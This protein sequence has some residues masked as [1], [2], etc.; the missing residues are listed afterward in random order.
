VEWRFKARQVLG[1]GENLFWGLNIFDFI[2]RLKQIFLGPTKFGGHKQF[3]GHC[4]RM[5]PLAAD[6]IQD[7][8]RQNTPVFR[9]LHAPKTETLFWFYT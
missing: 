3:G 2:I 6:L 7:E 9:R 4:P 1:L 5:L 8:E